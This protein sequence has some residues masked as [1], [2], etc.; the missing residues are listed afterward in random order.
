MRVRDIFSFR[1]K[2]WQE[3]IVPFPTEL[4][5]IQKIKI[6][7]YQSQQEALLD[8]QEIQKFLNFMQKGSCHKTLKG[9]TRYQIDIEHAQ[10]KSHYF[11]NGESLT[12]EK[13]GLVQ[14]S[15][16]PKKRGFEV[17]LHSFF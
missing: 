2:R 14:A 1:K 7:H 5:S 17:F 11:I 12:P 15:F 10:G 16:T 6:T 3:E 8:S 4:E 9:A 13:G